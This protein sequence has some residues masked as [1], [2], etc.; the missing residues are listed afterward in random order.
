MRWPYSKVLITV[1]IFLSDLM[2]CRD[3]KEYDK[4]LIKATAFKLGHELLHSPT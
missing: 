2:A 4:T 3:N 1:F